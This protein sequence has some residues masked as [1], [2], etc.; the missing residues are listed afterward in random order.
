MT[1][2]TASRTARR[3]TAAALLTAATFS[4]AATAHADSI[5][6]VQ[7]GDIW[8]SSPD[9][10]TKIQVTRGAGY[11]YASRADD[12]SFIALKGRRLHR[13]AADGR[14]IADFDTP[15]SGEQTAP[16]TSFF[17]GPF[18]PE[19]SPDGTKVAYEYWY[20]EFYTDPG[21]PLSSPLCTDSRVSTG[22][23]YSRSDRQTAWDEPGLGR[24]SG[25][26]D[27]SWIDNQTLL[28]SYKSVRPN[29]DT[30]IDHPG[31]G[32]QKIQEWFEDTNAW[33]MRDGEVS[34]RGDAAAFVSTT[35]RP[36]SD[37]RIGQ[38]DDQVSVYRLTAAPPALPEPCF[39]FV[40]PE[41]IYASPT[42]SADGSRIAFTAKHRESKEVT[43]Y[44]AQVPSQAAAC[45][46]PSSTG[47]PIATGVA[48]PDFSPAPMP[49]STVATPAG[50]GKGGGNGS[51]GSTGS[52]GAPSGTPSVPAGSAGGAGTPQASTGIAVAAG[53]GALRGLAAG[54][55][56]L[57][58]EVPTGGRLQLTVSVGRRTLGTAS[59]R[60]Q[61]AGRVAVAI[62]VGR[63]ARRALSGRRSVTLS[64]RYR[65]TPQQ[66]EP[67]TGTVALK[68]S[69]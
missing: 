30:I 11:S 12:G 42:F 51:G 69:R 17:R 60:A 27:P 53:R 14:L 16:K 54:K 29:V 4:C 50:G 19:I 47:S 34:R 56:R 2:R 26:V 52:G 8:V 31:D 33:Y 10:A 28:Q 23:G 39:S 21:C 22:I 3:A 43:L 13:L 25:W 41:V 7:N 67:V 1:T 68:L 44:V 15:V 63:T 62:P 64:V 6:Y 37:P 49:G 38:E 58:G 66:G 48:S 9:G 55:L 36:A 65:F 40:D 59:A 61:A 18:K 46:L 35:P 45:T 24:Q 5:S 32:N 57:N 20:Q